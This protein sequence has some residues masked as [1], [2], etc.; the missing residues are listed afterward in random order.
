M[1]DP[2]FNLLIALVP[3]SFLHRPQTSAEL[4]AFKLPFKTQTITVSQMWHPRLEMDLA[5]R[6]LR[7][8]VLAV[9]REI[10]G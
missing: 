10:Q 4:H 9:C 6:W 7:K 2:D 8:T 5:H 1:T 3:A